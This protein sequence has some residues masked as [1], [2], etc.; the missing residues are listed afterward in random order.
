MSF[1]DH[2]VH[3]RCRRCTTLW[4]T[5]A[6]CHRSVRT[7]A[8]TAVSLRF[9]RSFNDRGCD[10]RGRRRQRCYRAGWD[11][12]SEGGSG[13]GR[14]QRHFMLSI[15]FWLVFA[16]LG[17]LFGRDFIALFTV[18]PLCRRYGRRLCD[19]GDYRVLRRFPAVLSRNGSC[20][21]PA[22]R[23]YHMVT[24]SSARCSTASSTRSLIFRLF[25]L[26][27]ARY[28]RRGARNRPLP[29]PPY[30]SVFASM[31]ANQDV[32]IHVPRL[33]AGCPHPCG[34]RA[35][36]PARCLAATTEPLCDRT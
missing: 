16:V 1:S 11:R 13:R 2:A 32:R 30:Q 6:F 3:A 22:T 24:S 29:N 10:R 35:H 15:C 23:F 28:H 26:S 27:R 25:R 17:L 14:S 4:T 34:D 31:C 20:R 18:Y 7:A 33:P 36:R 21:R 5:S 9:R 19:G 12:K 8:L